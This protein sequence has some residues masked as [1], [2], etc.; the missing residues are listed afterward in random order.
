MRFSSWMYWDKLLYVL[1]IASLGIFRPDYALFGVF[2]FLI[3]YF[4]LTKRTNAFRH[5]FLA[6]SVALLWVII[7]REEYRYNQ[8][9]WVVSGLPVYPFLGWML[10]LTGAYL[11]YAH[12][13]THLK[14]H[15]A[16][17]F[18]FSIL[19]WVLLIITESIAYHWFGIQN[20]AAS[21]FVGLP[22]CDCIHAPRW[23]QFSYFALGPLYFF[24]CEAFGFEHPHRSRNF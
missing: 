23:M 5:L 12:W 20:S 7:A 14:S 16:H 10:G 9:L 21:A 22:L 19:F 17:F 11:L 6:G 4:I 8:T 18:S 1:A 2:L 13:N 15:V 24:L 3:P